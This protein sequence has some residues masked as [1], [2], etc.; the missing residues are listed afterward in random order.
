MFLGLSPLELVV[1]AGLA[2]TLFGPDK[3]PGAVR[4]AARILRHIRSAG[5]GARAEL[6]EQL[7][8]EIAELD[9]RRLSP[10]ALVREHLGDVLD[11]LRSTRDDVRGDLYD[12]R[13]AVR[14][15]EH[16]ERLAAVEAQPLASAASSPKATWAAEVSAVSQ[17]A[18]DAGSDAVGDAPEE[19]L[20]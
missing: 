19:H 17:A 10:R 14:I 16:A 18:R 2:L 9:P 4:E 8:P 13:D 15:D 11:P 3:L 6:L 1:L 5:E 12:M 20:T 7:G